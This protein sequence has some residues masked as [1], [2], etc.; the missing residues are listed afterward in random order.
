MFTMPRMSALIVC[1]PLALASLSGC[2]SKYATPGPAARMELFGVTQDVR[3]S[4]TDPVVRQATLKQ[5]LATFPAGLAMA[6]V[7]AS[8]YRNHCVSSYGA[9]Q[10]S[11]VTT[12]DIETD[13]DFARI[14]ALPQVRSLSPV[15]RLILSPTLES[16]LE[17]RRAAAS[18]GADILLVYTFDT[19]YRNDDWAP[20]LAL[21][22]LGVFPTEKTKVTTDAT[23]VL[24]DVRNGFVYGAVESTSKS[25]RINNF[26]TDEE[27]ADSAR[28]E[29]EREAFDGLLANLETAWGEVVQ[30]FALASPASVKAVVLDEDLQQLFPSRENGAKLMN[31]PPPGPHY[32]TRQ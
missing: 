12:K 22:S 26:W 29:A 24:L 1:A 2:F 19:Q 17:L 20:P 14:R 11:V 5:P 7:Q 13:K 9:G 3:D 28:K 8:G 27:A 10:Y 30:T 16:D 21:I 32:R 18:L 15:S 25:S 23:A 31:D 4:K 6:R